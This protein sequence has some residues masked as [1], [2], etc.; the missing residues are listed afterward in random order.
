VGDY[1]NA[2]VY[3]LPLT[4]SIYQQITELA[5]AYYDGYKLDEAACDAPTYRFHT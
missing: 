1:Q 3:T 5:E 2:S 4:V